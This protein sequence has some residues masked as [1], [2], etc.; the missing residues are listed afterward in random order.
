M[1]IFNLGYREIDVKDIE[2]K[3]LLLESFFLSVF[4]KNWLLSQYFESSTIILKVQ[5]NLDIK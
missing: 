5:S 4:N 1:V 3:N 2:D